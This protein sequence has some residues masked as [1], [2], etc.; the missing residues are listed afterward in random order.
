MPPILIHLNHEENVFI[1]THLNVISALD[2]T[3][4]PSLESR[5]LLK[6]LGDVIYINL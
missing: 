4:V 6:K 5:L 3:H 2:S 1:N